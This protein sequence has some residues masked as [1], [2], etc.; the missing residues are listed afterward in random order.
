MDEEDGVGEEEGK[1]ERKGRW[2][3]W[4]DGGKKGRWRGWVEMEMEMNRIEKSEN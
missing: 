1:V 4:G 3:G 2:R